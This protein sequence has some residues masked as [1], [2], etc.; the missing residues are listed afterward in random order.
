[1]QNSTLTVKL[2]NLISWEGEQAF[3]QQPMPNE[4][5]EPNLFLSNGRKDII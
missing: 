4:V 2:H 1:M 5:C 3:V